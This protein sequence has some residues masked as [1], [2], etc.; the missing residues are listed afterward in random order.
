MV[1]NKT[2]PAAKTACHIRPTW[3][4]AVR[5]LRQVRSPKFL[6]WIYCMKRPGPICD[7]NHCSVHSLP[8]LPNDLSCYLLGL[9]VLKKHLTRLPAQKHTRLPTR[10]HD[11]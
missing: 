4:L 1:A 7:E 3:L 2:A 9:L 11:V 8:D 6:D 5:L 10:D